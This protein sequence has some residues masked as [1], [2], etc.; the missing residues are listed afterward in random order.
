MTPGELGEN[1]ETLKFLWEITPAPGERGDGLRGENTRA[2]EASFP[3]GEKQRHIEE[4]WGS[5]RP[6]A[7]ESGVVW[8]RAT[9][10]FIAGTNPGRTGGPAERKGPW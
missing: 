8:G 4:R 10:I 3:S 6:L 1:G 5:L 2:C 9:G 7:K